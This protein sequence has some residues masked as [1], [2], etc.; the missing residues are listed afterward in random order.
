MAWQGCR[1]CCCTATACFADFNLFESQH[2]NDSSRKPSFFVFISHIQNV[3][4]NRTLWLVRLH[5]LSTKMEEEPFKSAE[6]VQEWLATDRN[7]PVPVAAAVAATLKTNGYDYPST[8]L[9]IRRADLDSLNISPPHGNLLFNKLRQQQDG[10]DALPTKRA[11]LHVKKSLIIDDATQEI[12]TNLQNGMVDSGGT[13]LEIQSCATAAQLYLQSHRLPLP[14]SKED[15]DEITA[16]LASEALNFGDFCQNCNVMIQVSDSDEE[17]PS[18][19]IEFLSYMEHSFSW[20]GETED[21]IHSFVE[22]AITGPIQ[23]F[24]GDAFRVSRNKSTKTSSGRADYSISYN[25]FQLFRGED[26]MRAK[27][28]QE[29]PAME[30]LNKS[31]KGQQW[32]ILYGPDVPYI[33]G[34]YSIGGTQNLL[35]QRMVLLWFS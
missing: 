15:V 3:R 5:L 33:F 14:M 16:K 2:Y 31:P 25:Y 1:C 21:E 12:R 32:D 18:A 13:A 6:A 35:L 23:K 8:L 34:Y 7:V 11:R 9:N 20:T 4:E 28:K 17:I 27:V 30:L 24:F 29:N 22:T 10:A 26:K 19:L